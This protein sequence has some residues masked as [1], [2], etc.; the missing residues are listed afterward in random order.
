MSINFNRRFPGSDGGDFL[1]SDYFDGTGLKN[2]RKRR[3]NQRFF[4]WLYGK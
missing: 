4:I 3:N 1:S 2:K